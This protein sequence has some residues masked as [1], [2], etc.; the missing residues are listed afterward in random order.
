M[1]EPMLERVETKRG[2]MRRRL[3]EEAHEEPVARPL[4]REVRRDP[5]WVNAV[6]R[7]KQLRL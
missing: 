2:T 4:G 6:R 3:V 7:L 5:I 1:N